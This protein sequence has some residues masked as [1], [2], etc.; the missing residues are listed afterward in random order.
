MD[1]DITKKDVENYIQSIY[2]LMYLAFKADITRVAT[3][4]LASEGG[5]APTNNLSKYFGLPKDIH[6]LSHASKGDGYTLWGQ[7]DQFLAK[8]FGYFINKLKETKEGDGTL[9]DNCLLFHGS[10]TSKTHKNVNYPLLLAG[11]RNLGHKSGQ[12]VQYE[13]EK[14]A[15]ADLYVRIANGAG[16]PITKFGDSLGNSMSELF[17][18]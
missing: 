14:N 16:V 9:L 2:D 10:A 7:W 13:E 17:T 1:L 8:Q 4:Q 5:S 18:G 6:A 3:Y 15:L 11:G 12:F